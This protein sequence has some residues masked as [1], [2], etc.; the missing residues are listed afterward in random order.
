MN[1]PTLTTPKRTAT[2]T[3]TV[4]GL[5]AADMDQ[6]LS[7]RLVD[8]FWGTVEMEAVADAFDRVEALLHHLELRSQVVES[9]AHGFS[10]EHSQ[11]A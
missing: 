3:T 6:L 2:S 11:A 7:A 10:M 4:R 9:S 5:Y 8:L 1:T